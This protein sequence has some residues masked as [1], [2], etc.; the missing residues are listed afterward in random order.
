MA[1]SLAVLEI[2]LL[3]TRGVWVAAFLV[4]LISIGLYSFH[5]KSQYRNNSLIALGIITVGIGLVVLF[6]G[7]EKI[8]DN[9][10]IQSRMHYWKASKEMFL[11]NPITG[12]GAGQWKVAYP[13]TGLK[14]TN[15]SVM[16]GDYLYST[17]A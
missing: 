6:S 8:I 2:L 10:T 1:V 3:Q 16:N 15:E 13:G 5:K 9:S 17:T 11:D 14:G 7:S 4:I 12:V